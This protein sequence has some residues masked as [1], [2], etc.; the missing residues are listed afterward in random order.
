MIKPRICHKVFH[1]VF[2]LA[3]ILAAQLL[4]LT[5]ATAQESAPPIL[6]LISVDGMRPDYVTSADAHGA[7]VPNLRRFLKEGAY[8]EGVTGV[9]P[10]VTYPSHTTLVT[11]VWPA[12]HGIFA[13]TTF[14]PLQKNN[15][16]WYWYAEDIRAPTL[17]DAAAAAGRTT[18]SV[19]WPVTVGAHITWNIPEFWRANTPDDAKLLRAVSTPGL[20][21]EARAALGDYPVGINSSAE[22]DELRARYAQWIL[23]HGHPGLLTLHLAALD[24]IEHETG[25]FSPESIAVLERLDAVIGT[26]RAAAERLALGRAFIAVVSDHGFVETRAQFNLFPAFRDAKL[27]TVDEKGKIAG[28]K[29]MPWVTGGSAAIVLKDSNDSATRAQV[30][31]L[32]GKLAADPANGIDRVLDADE[33]HQRGGFPPASFFV[34]LKPGWRTGSTLDGPVLS[35]TKIGGAH[36]ELP[37]LPDLRAAFFFVGG[38]GIPAGRSLGLVDMRDIAPTLAHAVGFSLP[39]ASGKNLLP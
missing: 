14:D 23:E 22:V 17:W 30:R 35:K 27:F 38:P 21:A 29:A 10:T 16:G 28:W 19:H 26:L 9:V 18:A 2:V 37:D 6:L 25:P 4:C 13:N 5:L 32:L 8:A 24:H 7:K 12:Q 36:G 34:G 1:L 33:L 31:E 15:Q 20:L 3:P 11:G 39:S